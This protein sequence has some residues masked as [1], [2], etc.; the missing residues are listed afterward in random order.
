MRKLWWSSAQSQ[1]KQDRPINET[2]KRGVWDNFHYRADDSLVKG[3][4]E[5]V[6]KAGRKEEKYHDR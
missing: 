2:I 6:R 4:L 1:T 5:C 3:D